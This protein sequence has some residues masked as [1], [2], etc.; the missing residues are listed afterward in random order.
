M[1]ELGLRLRIALENSGPL[2]PVREIIAR[3]IWTLR[4]MANAI[5]AG[6]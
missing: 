4:K 6:P 5:P 3:R 1:G 2:G